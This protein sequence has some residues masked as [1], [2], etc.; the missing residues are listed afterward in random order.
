MKNKLQTYG[1]SIKRLEEIMALIQAGNMDIDKLGGLLTEAQ[2]LI[3]FCR[4]RL[5]K[6]DEEIKAILDNISEDEVAI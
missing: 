3:K 4:S 1:E 2:E 5:Y 6:V